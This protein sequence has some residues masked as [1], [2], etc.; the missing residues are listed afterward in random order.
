MNADLE[1]AWACGLFEGEG[2]LW[3]GGTRR[4]SLTLAMTDRDVVERFALAVGQPIDRVR[5]YQQ[6]VFNRKLM[7]VVSVSRWD[8]LQPLLL[9]MRP[10]LS[11]RRVERLD[12]ILA[13]PPTRVVH[14]QLVPA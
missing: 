3:L 5:S 8:D 10:W 4:R 1:F 6:N 11:P 13:N 14:S 9:R 12:A 7:W 2:T